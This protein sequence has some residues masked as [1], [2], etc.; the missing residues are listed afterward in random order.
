MTALPPPLWLSH[1]LEIR[2]AHPTAHPSTLA[3]LLMSHHDVE[4]TGAQVQRLLDRFRPASVLHQGA[5]A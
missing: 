3:N 2:A 1:L 4:T 5:A